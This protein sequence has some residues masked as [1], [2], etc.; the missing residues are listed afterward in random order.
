MLRAL[1]TDLNLTGVYRERV[2]GSIAGVLIGRLYARQ[3]WRERPEFADRD[4]RP[5]I[6]TGMPRT[7]TTAL[8]KALSMDPQFQ[9]LE[10]WLAQTPM[11]RPP[12]DTWAGN[13]LFRKSAAA[14]SAVVEI[15]PLI[16]TIHD[17]VA[18]EADECLNAMVQ[19]FVSHSVQTRHC[20]FLSL[21]CVGFLLQDD[22]HVSAL[23]EPVLKLVRLL[24]IRA[25]A[26]C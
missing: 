18:D 1:D 23:R 11:A 22:A 6:I 19:S 13:P 25:S 24:T 4:P 12:R 9:G 2:F 3:G 16:K 20:T 8:H 5:L 21:P 15:A 26:G 14:M 17:M 7:G 10:L